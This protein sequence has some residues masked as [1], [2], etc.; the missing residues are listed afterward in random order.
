MRKI[1]M[2]PLLIGS[3]TSVSA[4]INSFEPSI[5]FP[6]KADV[7]PFLKANT[8]ADESNLNNMRTGLNKRN[9]HML[10]DN[11]QLSASLRT[12]RTWNYIF[13][14]RE[15]DKPDLICQYQVQFDEEMKVSASYF[16]RPACVQHLQSLPLGKVLETPAAVVA[17][18]PANEPVMADQ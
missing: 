5:V 6:K 4:A 16:D 17:P 12:E 3:C 7:L 1:W 8:Y 2:L 14:F 18:I 15:L 10:M 9:V 11:I 13:K